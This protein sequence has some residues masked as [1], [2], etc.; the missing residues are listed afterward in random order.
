M[1]KALLKHFL[2]L[3]EKGELN[4]D[5]DYKKYQKQIDQIKSSIEKGEFEIGLFDDI[6]NDIER[7]LIQEFLL[8]ATTKYS[9]TFTG[10]RIYDYSREDMEQY[11]FW[12]ANSLELTENFTNFVR[13]KKNS[14]R[15]LFY[16][17]INTKF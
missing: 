2:T 12:V 16:L 14:T 8:Y 5:I 6:L 4:I 3:N 15:N 7:R 1:V 9:D 11:L 10:T 17:S 13:M